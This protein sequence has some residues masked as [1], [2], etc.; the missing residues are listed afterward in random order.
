MSAVIMAAS[1]GRSHPP[2]EISSWGGVTV[3]VGYEAGY[4]V[5]VRYCVGRYSG[6]PFWKRNVGAPGLEAG[7]LLITLKCLM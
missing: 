4:T 2:P 6:G 5:R 7:Y 3:T 1:A